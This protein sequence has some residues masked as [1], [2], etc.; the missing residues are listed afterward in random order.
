V[1]TYVALIVGLPLD[2]RGAYY[3]GAL[4]WLALAAS[5]ATTAGGRAGPALAALLIVAQSWL[6]WRWVHELDHG[7]RSEAW[8]PTL[9]DELGNRGLVLG[10]ENWEWVEVM[11]HSRI[12]SVS[13]NSTQVPMNPAAPETLAFACGL[14]ERNRSRGRAVALTRW[15]VEDAAAKPLVAGL[16]ERYGA[17][18][19][20]RKP[21]YW[22][23]V[24]PAR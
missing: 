4:P 1:A 20:G 15:L 2:N 11:G 7:Y 21:E 3:L 19:P 12:D 10:L 23:L 17:L 6:G 16:V 14:I 8:V 22:L 24:P 9:A 18:R 13:L 5:Y